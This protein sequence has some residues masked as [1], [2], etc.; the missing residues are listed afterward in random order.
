MFTFTLFTVIVRFHVLGNRRRAKDKA[1]QRLYGD[2]TEIVRGSKLD[3]EIVRFMR[4]YSN[5][6]DGKLT[7]KNRA[8][9]RIRMLCEDRQ[10]LGTPT[11]EPLSELQC[12]SSGLR[13]E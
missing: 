5:I 1:V 6:L 4:G 10:G 11:I 13:S 2:R 12:Q 8:I 7:Q 3:R 9:S